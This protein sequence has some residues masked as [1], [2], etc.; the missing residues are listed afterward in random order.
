MPCS[1]FIRPVGVRPEEPHAT[2]FVASRAKSLCA[3]LCEGIR[4]GV[5]LTV[6]IFILV[7]VGMMLG[8]L[9]RLQLDRTGV[10]LLGAIV[11]VAAGML[12]LDDAVAAVDIGTVALLF[13]LM[14]VS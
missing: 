9:P 4:G 5:T 10:A 8:R 14:V 3:I 1:P 7:Y 12:P 13:A 11:L 2:C 6:V